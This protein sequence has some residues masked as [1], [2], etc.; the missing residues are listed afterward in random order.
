[1]SET[2]N[3]NDPRLQRVK[4]N[5]QRAAYLTLPPEV[6]ERGFVRPVRTS[7]THVGIAGPTYPLRA[8][9]LV[10]QERFRDFKYAFFEAYPP[11]H[12]LSG[13]YWRQS[14]IDKV[15]KGC[16]VTTTMG[17]S[18]AETYARD[19]HFYGSTYCCGCATHLP[20]G[21]AGEFVWEGTD[22]RVGS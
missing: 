18:I 19:P 16:G 20:V 1:M 9:T 2:H 11:D 12:A 17:V 5:G 21:E 4:D 7:Y 13:R 3:V 6:R 14:D 8:L 10:E 22:E 15:G